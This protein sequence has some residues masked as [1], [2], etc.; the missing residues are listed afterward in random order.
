[1]LILASTS[2]YRRAQLE[3]LGIPFASADPGIDEDALFQVGESPP[4]VALRLAEAKVRAVKIKN[5]A[6]VVLGGDQLVSLDDAILG[7][8][9][10]EEGAVQQLLRLSGRSHTLW[11]AVALAHGSHLHTHLDRSVLTMRRLDEPSIRRYVALDRPWD[12]AGS[13]KFER[14]GIALFERVET[15]DP[16]AIQGL[17]LIAVAAL[18]R[19]EGVSVF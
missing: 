2:P 4:E 16:S 17:P 6:A 14:A 18:L 7:K 8:A 12:C 10:S 1:M 9:H 5:P 19:S 3:Q 15:E 11:T 13:Y